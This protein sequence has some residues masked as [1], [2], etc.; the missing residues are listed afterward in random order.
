MD[1]RK[2]KRKEKNKERE[3]RKEREK[4]IFHL[5]CLNIGKKEKKKM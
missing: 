5:M 4:K 1:I 3:M 2:G